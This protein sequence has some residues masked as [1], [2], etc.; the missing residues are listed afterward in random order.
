MAANSLNIAGRAE[1]R[2]WARAGEVTKFLIPY[3][4][5]IAIDSEQLLKLP[6]VII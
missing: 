1:L 2:L 5:R 3:R 4:A 6:S